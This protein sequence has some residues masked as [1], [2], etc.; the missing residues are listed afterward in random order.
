[1][2]QQDQISAQRK[3]VNNEVTPLAKKI[4]IIDS[5][6]AMK[7]QLYMSSVSGNS[8][9]GEGNTAGERSWVAF[10]FNGGEFISLSEIN[11]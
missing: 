4:W 6:R 10:F 5:C 7:S 3:E 2:S 11:P 1:M 8:L 9:M